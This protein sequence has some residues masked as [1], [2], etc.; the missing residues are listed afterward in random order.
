MNQSVLERISKYCAASERST[1]DVLSKLI[2]WGIPIEESEIILAKLR[3]EKFLDDKRYA[4]S[5]VT[6]K[7]NLDKW[8]KIKIENALQLKHIDPSIIQE[9]ISVIDDEEYLQALHE[10]LEKKYKEVKST[11]SMDDAR[12]I[13]MFALSRGFEEELIQEWLEKQGFDCP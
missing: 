8:G 4:N 9:A 1:H 12:R 5:Y 10:L 13:L 6:E 2:S 7:W 3:A 11:N